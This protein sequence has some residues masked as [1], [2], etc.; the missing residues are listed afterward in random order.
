MVYCGLA[1]AAS[2]PAGGACAAWA[3][4]PTAAPRFILSAAIIARPT[5]LCVPFI[6]ISPRSN[7]NR[8]DSLPVHPGNLYREFLLSFGKLWDYREDAKPPQVVKC[9]TNNLLRFAI[10]RPTVSFCDSSGDWM[11]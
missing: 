5:I 7:Y 4:V 6:P 2:C 10:R 9:M 3:M 1:P 11:S 8:W